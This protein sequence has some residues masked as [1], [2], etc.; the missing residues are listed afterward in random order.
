MT[1]IPELTPKQIANAISG[2]LHERL[3]KG[4]FQNGGDISAL[5]KFIGMTQRDF[6]QA[7]GLDVTTLQGWEQGRR[8]PRG[9][10]VALLT[11]AARHPGI[12][13]ENL[14]LLKPA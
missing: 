3:M 8:K 7:L 14:E 6:A 1:E 5:R 2:R 13:H 12:L 10:S 9:P 11:I 4:D